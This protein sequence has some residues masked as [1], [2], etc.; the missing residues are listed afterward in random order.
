MLSDLENIA[1]C[2]DENQLETFGYDGALLLVGRS[3]NRSIKSL[4]YEFR[5]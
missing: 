5:K 2:C 1:H 4:N 3:I